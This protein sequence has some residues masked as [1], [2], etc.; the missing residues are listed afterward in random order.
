MP[1]MPV[2]SSLAA[3]ACC[4]AAGQA[5]TVAGGLPSGI[6]AQG[7]C[8]AVLDCGGA[9]VPGV[10]LHRDLPADMLHCLIGWQGKGGPIDPIGPIGSTRGGTAMSAVPF[11]PAVTAAL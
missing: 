2:P 3:V 8:R 11:C 7:W 4:H 1:P 6:L 9:R 5:L 10:P